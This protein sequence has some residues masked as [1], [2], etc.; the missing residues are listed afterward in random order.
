[1]RLS[2]IKLAGFKSFVDP[3]TV[4]LKSNLVGVVGPNGSGKSNIID[5]VRWV[6]GE[7]SAKHLRG[8]SM[9]DVIFN[10][11]SSRKPVGQASIELV[12]D[13]SEGKLGGQYANFMEISVKRVVNRDGQSGYFLNGA[14]CRRK[15]ITDLFLG[16]GLGPRSYA[17]IEQGMISRMIEA[18]PEELRATI[19]EAAG[20]S[21]YKERRRETETRIRSTKE[22]LDRINDLRDELG[23]Q[24][25]RLQRQSR[26]AERFKELKQQERD[27]RGQLLALQWQSLD[28]KAREV[29]GGV[30]SLEVKLE[31]ELATQRSAEAGIERQREA[32]TESND[33]FNEIQGKFYQVGADISTKE[34]FIAHTRDR[35]RQLST[36][37]DQ[38]E[39]SLQEM[40][41]HQTADHE[42]LM[43]LELREQELA[44]RYEMAAETSA[45]ARVQQTEAESAMQDWQNQ[46]DA[47]NQSANEPARQAE[48]E[49]TTITHME[50]QSRQLEQRHQRLQEEM[51]GLNFADLESELELVNE[52]IENEQQQAESLL[53]NRQDTQTKLAEQREQ[54][55]ALNRQLS[56]VRDQSQALSGR[57]A[58]LEALQ[59]TALGKSNSQVG[60]WL[61]NNGLASASRLAQGIDTESGWEKAV[62]SVLGFHLEA[63]CVDNLADIPQAL[64]RLER[65]ALEIFNLQNSGVSLTANEALGLPTLWSKIN[66]RWPV[67]SLFAGV[68]CAETLEQ[69]LAAQNKLQ[70]NESIVTRDG[71]WLGAQWLRI[72][73]SQDEKA[74]V[75]Q[76]EKALR[77][78][79]AEKSAFAEQLD[80]L[81]ASLLQARD[82]QAQLE[83][84][85]DRIQAQ[86]SEFERRL[87]D[88]KA[89]RS[90]KQARVDQLRKRKDT[91]VGDMEELQMQLQTNSE[92][93]AEARG[94]LEEAVERMEELAI[95]R[96]ELQQ[97]REELRLRLDEAR[98]AASQDAVAMQALTA[99]YTAVKS[100]ITSTQQSLARVENQLRQ[101]QQ[102]RD[103][104]LESLNIDDNP[105]ASLT[106]E[107]EGLL[108]VRLEVEGRLAEARRAM[109]AADAEMRELTTK[110]MLAE[111]R[112]H[113]VRSSLEH[114]RMEAQ[115]LRVR[116]QTIQEQLT[117][118]GYEL[119]LLFEGLSD[120]A[121]IAEWEEALRDLEQK[122]Q[123]LGPIN[124]AAIDEYNEQSQRKEHIEAQYKDLMDALETLENAIRKIDR[125]T[126]ARFKETFDFIN[127]GLKR[128][129]PKLFG[130]GQA[131]LEMTGEDLL[132]TGVTIMA[133][134]P[135]K[136][137]TNIH[138]LSGGEK[139]LTAAALVFSIFE[140]NPAPF[141]M[142]DEVDAPLD[143]ANVGR[144]CDLV[145]E[146][147]KQVQFIFITHNKAT[148]EISN[149]SM[150]SPCMSRVSPA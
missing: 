77:D 145:K 118:A 36:D 140:L 89:S 68:Y 49:R 122:I 61:R 47:F 75:L 45:Q 86:L 70:G 31:E 80:T 24:L 3:T 102:R 10:G 9:A 17:I 115:T 66:S 71:L 22:N 111:Q 69:A 23:K 74:G 37:L 116:R 91:I 59:E 2:K 107:L 96:E 103:M 147:S 125:E 128:M 46:W 7:T 84:E 78:A 117:E 60:D 48:V 141:C 94:R 104:L 58:S 95:R 139:A 142:L 129:F 106:E 41:A 44:P 92:N 113:M 21:K 134:P 133:R 136:R 132:D 16:T 54:I 55:T 90:G 82:T 5:A 67:Q 98:A 42:R 93:I 137:V 108:A 65:G 20:I 149:S 150:V 112:V 123:K 126:R 87:G 146:M 26:T 97:R 110:R 38:A 57:I 73:R 62:E 109:E 19:E 143:E 12:F 13:N 51:L 100:N 32:H 27:T 105:I 83:E 120:T 11:S 8:G 50:V 14:R 121:N 63:V 72:N 127:N 138:L 124:L 1:M 34:Q 53:Y 43:E 101:L 88:L 29:E 130:G 33:V 81:E 148:M 119:H 56:A 131:Y 15:D 28:E 64:S 76:R 99:E 30:T 18:K 40:Q 25:E 114:D 4:I 79:I 35:Q 6:M 135:G 144:F 85:R 52:Q 39:R